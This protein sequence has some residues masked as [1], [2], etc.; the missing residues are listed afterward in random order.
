MK[1][2]YMI[3]FITS[4]LYSSNQITDEKEKTF[5]IKEIVKKVV[6]ENI[7]YIKLN[8]LN[9]QQKEVLTLKVSVNT[10]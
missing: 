5:M 10:K 7:D 2:V 1:I 6:L 9:L 8:N 4:F 3:L